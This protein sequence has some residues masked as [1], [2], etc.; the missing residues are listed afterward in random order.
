ME[1]AQASRRLADLAFRQ[2]WQGI[3]VFMIPAAMAMVGGYYLDD[4][5][6]AGKTWTIM[7]LAVALIIS[8]L[9]I[10]RRYVT[11]KRVVKRIKSDWIN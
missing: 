4:R 5:W 11:F 1:Q 6:Q 9:I 2:A 3:F 7:G 10:W 8:W